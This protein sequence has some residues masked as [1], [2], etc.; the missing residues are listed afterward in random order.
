MRGILIVGYLVQWFQIELNRPLLVNCTCVAWAHLMKKVLYV[1]D[2]FWKGRSIIK[3]IVDF[4]SSLTF[5][6]LSKSLSNPVSCATVYNPDAS[7]RQ[8]VT[9]IIIRLAGFVPFR[10]FPGICGFLV[11]NLAQTLVYLPLIASGW[12]KWWNLIL[13]PSTILD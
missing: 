1:K 3:N 8:S 13:Q 12:V 4:I 5:L 6:N 10:L 9:W 11:K 2:I 7:S